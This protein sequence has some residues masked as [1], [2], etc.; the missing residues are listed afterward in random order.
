MLVGRNRHQQLGTNAVGAADED[1]VL[2]RRHRL[3]QGKQAAEAADTGQHT[4]DVGGAGALADALDGVVAGI[5]IDPGF[6]VGQ[7]RLGHAHS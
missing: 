6:F 4:G 5:D 3:F 2:Q 1:R 7:W